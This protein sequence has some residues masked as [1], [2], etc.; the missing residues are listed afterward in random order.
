LIEIRFLVLQ[1]TRRPPF[2]RGDN[3]LGGCHGHLL[4][5]PPFHPAIQKIIE[6]IGILEAREI[7]CLNINRPEKSVKEI[8]E[9]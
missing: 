7:L 3:P 8:L 2:A 9:I 5:T 6:L 4:V 1:E